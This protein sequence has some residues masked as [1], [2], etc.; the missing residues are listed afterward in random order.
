MAKPSV[1]RSTIPTVDPV[2][3]TLQQKLTSELD[4]ANLCTER[5]FSLLTM[6]VESL[7]R[8]GIDDDYGLA[9]CLENAVEVELNPA[10]DRIRD[11]LALVP[12][13]GHG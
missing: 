1:A 6:V 12:E 3:P 13:V 2:T 9:I 5:M 10:R 4:A 8:R 7:Y 11:A